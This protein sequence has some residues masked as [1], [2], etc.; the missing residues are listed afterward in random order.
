[1]QTICYFGFTLRNIASKEQSHLAGVIL[2]TVK[3]VSHYQRANLSQKQSFFNLAM[4]CT[5]GLKQLRMNF[6][7]FKYS[8]EFKKE[9]ASQFLN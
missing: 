9:N 2:L 5:S 7:H 6:L 1:L 8:H 4:Q 3:L